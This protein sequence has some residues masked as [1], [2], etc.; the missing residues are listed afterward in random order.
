MPLLFDDIVRTYTGPAQRSESH[1]HFYNQSALPAVDRLRKMLQRWVCRFPE[2]KRND[3][4]NRMRHEGTGSRSEDRSFDSA[5]FELAVHEFLRGTGAE[6]EVDPNI[7]GRT[8]DFSAAER[9][10]VA[11][12]QKYYVEALDISTADNT[13]LEISWND[14]SCEDVLNEIESPDFY[15]LVEASGVLESMPRKQA[16]KAPFQRLLAEVDY[17]DVSAGYEGSGNWDTLP[18][19]T[20]KH[21]DWEL[22]GRLLPVSPSRRPKQTGSRFVGSSF[23]GAGTFDDVGKPRNRL[24]VK[25]KRYRHVPRLII[26]V[27]EDEWG[28][29][30]NE[31]LFGTQTYTFYVNADPHDKSPVPE[32][33]PSQRMDGFWC[34]SSGPQNQHVV[35]VLLFRTLYAHCVHRAQVTFYSNPYVDV[36]LPSWTRAI[37]HS[38]YR[39][40]KIT[41]ANGLPPSTYMTDHEAIDDLFEGTPLSRTAREQ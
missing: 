4:V 2:D 19:A 17:D 31:V 41:I 16:L 35:G 7:A 34:N 20:F 6:V 29:R 39:D 15:L 10:P 22:T 26:A 23:G 33:H 5:F 38:E 25:A 3:I 8:P 12:G 28:I 37:P 32:P 30:M 14:K 24:D 11:D 36:A 18:S 21:G 9:Y 1:F 40:G 13:G 27:S